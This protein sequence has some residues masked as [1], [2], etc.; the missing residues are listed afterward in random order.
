MQLMG[1][2]REG[3]VQQGNELLVDLFQHRQHYIIN[4]FW[5]NTSDKV[6]K[7]VVYHRLCIGYMVNIIQVQSYP[8]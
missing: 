8:F 1:Y 4:L 6:Q 5:T 7:K 3:V 2:F